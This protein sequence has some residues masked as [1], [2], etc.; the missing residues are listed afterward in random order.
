MLLSRCLAV[1][2]VPLLGLA[3][4]FVSE[5]AAAQAVNR[6]Y[7]TASIQAGFKLYGAQ[8]AFCHAN[9]G[10]G[11]QGISLA[12]QQ[13]RRASSDDDIKS[14]ITNGVPAGGMPPFQFQQVEL[15]AIVAYIRS[16][17]DLSGAPFTVGDAARGKAIYDGTGGCAACHRVHGNG[18]R[19]APDLSDIGVVRKPSGI[20]RS[21]VAPTAGMLPIN[22]PTRIVTRDGRTIVGRRL[23]EDTH[24]VQLIDRQERLVSLLKTDIKQLDLGTTSEMPSYADRLSDGDLAD[25]LAYLLSLRG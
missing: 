14:T 12:R 2:A 4:L 11:I 16:G 17:F 19:A 20:L 9:N 22:R 25:L 8:C 6:E 5:N 21:I 1:A 7:S 3:A 15:D 18:S 23:N 10:D 24:S 13:F